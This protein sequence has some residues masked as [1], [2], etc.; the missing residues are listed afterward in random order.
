MDRLNRM[1]GCSKSHPWE[2]V[3]VYLRTVLWI[4]IRLDWGFHWT[5]LHSKPLELSL[6]QVDEGC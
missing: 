1:M 6:L 4:S 5:L 2:A 3:R